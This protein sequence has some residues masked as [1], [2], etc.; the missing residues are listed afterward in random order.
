MSRVACGGHHLVLLTLQDEVWVAGKNDHGQLG[1]CDDEAEERQPLPVL[2]EPCSGLK[3]ERVACGYDHTVLV[4]REGA[5]WTFGHNANG[6]LGLGHCDSVSG[7]R[8]VAAFRSARLDA[9]LEGSG[10]GDGD[11]A[12]AGMAHVRVVEVSSKPQGLQSRVLSH[13]H[14]QRSTR[15]SSSVSAPADLTLT[16]TLTLTLAAL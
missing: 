15:S 14:Q 2:L 6:E 4:T 8:Q 1:V 12:Q 11:A 9:A 7:P 16:L 3:V 13:H 10:G 5:L